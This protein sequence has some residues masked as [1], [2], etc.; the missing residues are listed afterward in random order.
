MS[1]DASVS[2]VPS[3][4]QAN[5]VE[6]TTMDSDRAGGEKNPSADVEE[7]SGVPENQPLELIDE[8]SSVPPIGPELD[9][10]N[11]T[12]ELDNLQA[13]AEAL[14]EQ[15]RTF[16][17]RA[18]V[19]TDTSRDESATSLQGDS[20]EPSDAG[21]VSQDLHSSPVGSRGEGHVSEPASTLETN[22]NARLRPHPDDQSAVT[23]SEGAKEGKSAAG[24][25]QE[26]QEDDDEEVDDED[27][28]DP[29]PLLKY[30]RLGGNLAN[31]LAKDSVSTVCVSDRFLVS[32]ILDRMLAET[33]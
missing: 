29:E 18:A 25:G 4:S 30:S 10:P 6:K 27:E 32:W 23:P 24:E 26:D 13:E 22:E 16:K 19:E 2:P 21:S 14:T 28:D 11:F 5:E 7:S 15:A 9:S 8:T 31:V 1:D 17:K 33:F 12:A 3:E 20:R